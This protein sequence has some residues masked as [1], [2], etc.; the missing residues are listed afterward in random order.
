MYRER[1]RK[2][3]RELELEFLLLQ[4]QI[5][6]TILQTDIISTNKQLINAVKCAGTSESLVKFRLWT[7]I[8]VYNTQ[9]FSQTCDSN[10]HGRPI[11]TKS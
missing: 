8:Y 7:H 1:E 4:T 10:K 11:V 6:M 9:T 5:S 2:R 3:E